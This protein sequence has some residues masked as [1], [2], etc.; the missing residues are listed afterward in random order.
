MKVLLA[1]GHI[2][3]LFVFY[4]GLKIFIVRSKYILLRV[5]N[6]SKQTK[7]EIGLNTIWKNEFNHRP[8]KDIGKKNV[9]PARGNRTTPDFEEYA[10]FGN[11][12]RE[13]ND[14]VN[15]A[16]CQCSCNGCT[17]KGCSGAR[18]RSLRRHGNNTLHWN[19][20]KR[21]NSDANILI[22]VIIN[23]NPCQNDRKV[24]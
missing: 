14:L 3:F 10:G 9:R 15:V 11:D 18:G 13:G 4:C 19:F 17:P 12:Y 16:A 2:L 20:Y 7:G 24:L 5:E 8:I 22:I 1:N 6:Y 21:Y 23:K